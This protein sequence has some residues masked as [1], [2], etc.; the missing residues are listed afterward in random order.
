MSRHPFHP[1]AAVL[2]LVAIVVSV[3][4]AAFGVEQTD[5]AL[6]VAGGAAAL[7]LL[8]IPWRGRDRETVDAAAPAGEP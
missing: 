5:P 6:A 3:V 1:L 8:V 4:V 7:G 2:G